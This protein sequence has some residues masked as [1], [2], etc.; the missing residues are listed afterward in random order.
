MKF[1]FCKIINAKAFGADFAELNA[2]GVLLMNDE[3]LSA[4]KNSVEQGEI[5]VYSANSLVPADVRLTGP[6]VDYEK[7]RAHSEK[8]FGILND[9]GV[10]ML[11]FGSGTAKHVPDGFSMEKAWEQLVK[12]GQIFSEVAEKY[13]QT[14]AIEGLNRGECNIINTLSDVYEYVVRIN[15]S[16]VLMLADFYHMYRNGEPISDIKKYKDHLVHCHI[17]GYLNRS[18]PIEEELGFVRECITALKKIDYQGGLSFEGR[19]DI[20]KPHEIISM[21]NTFRQFADT[22]DEK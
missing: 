4:L 17:A 19:S 14:V 21:F 16:N 2:L 11:V 13:G 3:Q 6:D 10:K 20:E 15:R 7:I 1:G 18:V 22:S 8:C 5:P 9:L 12:V